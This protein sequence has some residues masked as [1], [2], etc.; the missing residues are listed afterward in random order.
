MAGTWMESEAVVEVVAA[1]IKHMRQEFN[2]GDPSPLETLIFA[3][4]KSPEDAPTQPIEA[5]VEGIISAGKPPPVEAAVDDVLEEAILRARLEMKRYSTRGSSALEAFRNGVEGIMNT[6]VMRHALVERLIQASRVPLSQSA[7]EAIYTNSFRIAVEQVREMTILLEK[8]PGEAL[9][10]A[11]DRST[12]EPLTREVC[13]KAIACSIKAFE[14]EM[15][16]QEK[17]AFKDA[18]TAAFDDV[19]EQNFFDC[20]LGH[21]I[22]HLMTAQQNINLMEENLI[23]QLVFC[24]KPA[25]A[26]RYATM[27]ASI[28]LLAR[29][30]NLP[31]SDQINFYSQPKLEEEED[32]QQVL[33]FFNSTTIHSGDWTPGTDMSSLSISLPILSNEKRSMEERTSIGY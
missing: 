25:S 26:Q 2:N 1:A 23:N 22:H 9:M 18:I 17:E 32:V 27:H 7:I 6:P 14:A 3:V 28:R 15:Y 8:S 16:L 24:S 4:Q 12:E 13:K 5:I 10:A 19:A 31:P 20:P 11:V 21:F 33:D 29:H 30:S